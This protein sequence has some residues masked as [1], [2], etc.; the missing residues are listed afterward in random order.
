[1]KKTI[2]TCSLLALCVGAHAQEKPASIPALQDAAAPALKPVSIPAITWKGDLR[3]R[4]ENIDQ[5][6]KPSRTRDRIRAR[7]ALEAKVNDEVKAI[8]GLASGNDDP[9]STNQTLGDS[10]TTKDI[11]LDLANAVWSPSEVK[12][13][14]LTF[15]KMA[16]PF[17]CVQ[18]LIWDGDLN[19]EGIAANYEFKASEEL[20]LLANAGYFWVVER[21][22]ASDTMLYTGQVAAKMKPAEGSHV[23]VGAGYYSYSS[24]EGQGLL[25]DEEKS[26]GN[27][28]REDGD[29]LVYDNGFDEIEGFAEI[30]MDYGIPVKVYGQYVLNEA[31]DTDDTG[32]LVGFTLG[33]AKVPGSVELGYNYRRLE[34]NAVLGAFT[35]SDFIG[36]GTDGV[37]HKLYATVALSK[38]WSLGGAYIINEKG[39]DD[40]IDYNRLQIDLQAKF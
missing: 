15:G 12:G 29:V 3:Y 37:G 14:S 32:Y 19:P 6:G 9:V 26:F 34:A 21:S 31:A 30:G 36:G 10:F 25:Y 28:T 4:Y 5:E 23:L 2:V 18:D 17:M 16:K 27:A 39:L 11:G 13:L 33:R 8:V 40:S 38:N 24:I 7:I 22:A 35:D 20:S 1:M